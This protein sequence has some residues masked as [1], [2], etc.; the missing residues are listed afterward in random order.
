MLSIRK[1]IFKTKP[2]AILFFLAFLF[3]GTAENLFAFEITKNEK[4]VK[5]GYYEKSLFAEGMESDAPKESYGY[6]Y[7]QEISYFAKWRYEYVYG[8]FEELFEKLKKGEIDLL[9]GIRFTEERTEFF[10]FPDYTMSSNKNGD[11]Y[12]CTAK[13]RLDLLSDLNSVLY[14]ITSN[15][16]F[17]KKDLEEKYY[18]PIPIN[19][20][21]LKIIENYVAKHDF[22]KIGYFNDYLPFCDTDSSGNAT[23]A[24][25]EIMRAMLS[26]LNIQDK[27][28]P[29]YIAYNS[30]EEMLSDLKDKKIDVFYPFSADAWLAEKNRLYLSRTAVK[31]GMYLAYAKIFSNEDNGNNRDKQ[32]QPSPDALREKKL[33]ARENRFLRLNRR[34]SAC[35][36]NKKSKLHNN[37]LASRRNNFKQQKVSENSFYAASSPGRTL[38]WS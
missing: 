35:N 37:K 26:A 30:F 24:V 3:L 28:A 22:I 36:F 11:Y 32:K 10:N 2:A 25:V 1:I 20:L 17:F 15:Y 29:E 13:N 33:A 7:L 16:P 27:I 34:M 9:G 14:I 31:S 4:T 21:L 6:E 19:S 18:K 5:V 38:L 8:T 23:G 12:L